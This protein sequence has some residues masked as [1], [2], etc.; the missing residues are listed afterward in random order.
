MSI[1][2]NLGIG[3]K[4][5]IIDW[6][7]QRG[8][9]KYN[10]T[11]DLS[12][13]IKDDLFIINNINEL[14]CPIR[15]AVIFEVHNSYINNLDIIPRISESVKFNNCKFPN[16]LTFDFLTKRLVITGGSI[17]KIKEINIRGLNL[18][19]ITNT[20]I[21]EMPPLIN[22]RSVF[23][24]KNQITAAP[25]CKN[26]KEL[27]LESNNIK[28]LSK[29]NNVKCVYLG[30]LN[31]KNFSLDGL[32]KVN[33]LY[34]T[35]PADANLNQLLNNNIKIKGL[36]LAYNS[37]PSEYTTE[38]LYK[39]KIKYPDMICDFEIDQHSI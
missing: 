23:L 7:K 11:K 34:L 20:N 21:S 15:S 5:E 30:S 13:N 25:F 38:L 17:K 26:V 29:A 32:K 3:K 22:I 10:I 27:G 36:I 1:L 2:K 31:N 6:C 33:S 18:L 4:Q 24:S 28:D 19:S 39:L 12:L 8:I 9:K 16:D 37:E 14:I 35:N